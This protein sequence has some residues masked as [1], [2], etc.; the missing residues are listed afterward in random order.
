[1]SHADTILRTAKAL[2]AARFHMP[3][4]ASADAYA[5]LDRFLKANDTARNGARSKLGALKKV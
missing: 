3:K 2:R 1:M 4:R 5:Q